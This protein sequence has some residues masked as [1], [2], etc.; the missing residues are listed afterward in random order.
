MPGLILDY[1]YL[2][3]P[4]LG[5]ANAMYTDEEKTLLIDGTE[6]LVLLEF[7]SKHNCTLEISLGL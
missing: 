7:C 1:F 6:S 4:G 5:N 2:Q 3:A